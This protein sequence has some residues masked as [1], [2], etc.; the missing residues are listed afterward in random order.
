MPDND[1]IETVEVDPERCRSGTARIM[2]DEYDYTGTYLLMV[3]LAV[4]VVR[5]W[6]YCR[7]ARAKFRIA[8]QRLREANEAFMR[9]AEEG[10]NITVPAWVRNER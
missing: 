6:R 3:A 9:T 5:E 8:E 7:M 2:N 4:W 1:R 10:N